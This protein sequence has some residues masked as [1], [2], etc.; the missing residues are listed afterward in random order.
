MLTTAKER[1]VTVLALLAG[2]FLVFVS[3]VGF[4]FPDDGPDGVDRAF[5]LIP[6]AAGLA[7]FGGLWGLRSGS[8]KVS[9]ANGLIVIGLIAVA[10]FWWMFFVPAVIAVTVLV[11]GVMKRGLEREL[12]LT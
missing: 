2:G 7:L 8:M 1:W 4:V 3:I 5:W 9:V 11:A 6:F 12:S 10:S